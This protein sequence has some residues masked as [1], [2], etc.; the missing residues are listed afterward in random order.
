MSNTVLENGDTKVSDSSLTHMGLEL[1][2]IKAG[3]KKRK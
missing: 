1:K 3:N 2:L